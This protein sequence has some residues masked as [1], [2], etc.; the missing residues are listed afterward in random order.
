MGFEDF[1]EEMEP[2]IIIMA[3]AMAI[4]FILVVINYIFC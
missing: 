2:L 1:Y 3:V 4:I